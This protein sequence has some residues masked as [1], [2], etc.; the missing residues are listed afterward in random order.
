MS[1]TLNTPI[2]ALEIE[3]P[4]RAIEYS[5]RR[6]TGGRGAHKGGD[7]LVRDIKALEEMEFELLTERRRHHPR[8]ASGGEP[9]QT[10]RNLLV[11]ADGKTTELE[12]KTGGR[13][14]PGQ[15]LRMETPGGGGFGEP[16]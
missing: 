7:G 8:G 6:G 4:L 3:F 9:G 13:L 2:E 15:R 12:P 1:N 16:Q 14:G 10:G 5:V 11:D